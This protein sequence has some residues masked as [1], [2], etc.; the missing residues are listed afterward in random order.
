MANELV[1]SSTSS[2]ELQIALLSDRRLVEFH[3]ERQNNQFAVGDVFLGEVQRVLPSL[4][5]VFVDIGSGK[6]AFLHY[7]DLGPQ[8]R[9]QIRY[10]KSVLASRS[11]V[12][13]LSRISPL[14]DINKHGKMA[15]VLKPGQPVLVQI[16]K[17][18]IST[19]GPR[20]SCQLSL[21]GEYIILMPFGEDVSVSRKFK[22]FEEKKRVRQLLEGIKPKNVGII[23]RTAAEDRDFDKLK[24]DL[25]R[26]LE[27]WDW[28]VEAMAEAKPPR[29][30]LS[31]MDRTTSILRDMLSVGFDAIY[32]DDER[33]YQ[34]IKDYLETNQPE[35]V[36]S[37]T[38]RRTRT[39]LFESLG[40]DRQVKSLFGRQ[41]NLPNGSYLVIEHTEALHVI[42][43]NSGS[44]R[45]GSGED[46]EAGILRINLA[47]AEE[48]ARQLRLRDMGGIIVVD[49]IDQR[50]QENRRKV[51]DRLVEEMGRERTRH[52]ILP[53]SRF[54]LIEITRQRVRP[55]VNIVTDELC[56]SCN[57]TGKIQPSIVLVDAIEHNLDYLIQKNRVKKL[58]LLVNPFM[59]AFLKYGFPSQ[60]HRWF[61]RYR[62]WIKIQSSQALPFTTVRYYDENDEEIRLD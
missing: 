16:M 19:K 2:G 29:K 42:D 59:A 4:N 31:E 18:P 41:V 58:K 7:L 48:V 46:P 24:E 25:Q 49:F 32:T 55:E 35:N 57:G 62:K 45:V 5:A 61:F 60:Q 30:L 13:P 27:K 3:T 15:D 54:G 50:H 1:V 20:V 28:I 8:I 33:V 9:T 43:V 6:D 53:M 17:E 39:G 36:K 56:P 14:E 26:L 23:A 37:L 44:V 34:D 21:A 38:M 40:I 11:N 22:S 52:T 10:V 12:T 47:A 51:Y